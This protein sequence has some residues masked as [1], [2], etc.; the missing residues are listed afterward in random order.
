MQFR[1]IDSVLKLSFFVDNCIVIIDN[2]KGR[3]NVKVK[4]D[5]NA[6]FNIDCI[7]NIDLDGLLVSALSNESLLNNR[8]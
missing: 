1:L 7:S 2:P 6:L 8:D 3:A 4:A 5:V